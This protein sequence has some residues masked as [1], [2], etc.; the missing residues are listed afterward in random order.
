MNGRGDNQREVDAVPLQTAVLCVDCESVTD[1][2]SNQ[3]PVCGS[4][5]IFNLFKVLG[6]T[7]LKR[8]TKD[9]SGVERFVQ[10]DLKMTIS[11]QQMRAHDLNEIVE[12]IALLI[13]P[14]LARGQASFHINVKPVADKLGKR[15][16]KVA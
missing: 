11:L 8:K 7:L 3:C 2:R 5:S 14:K 15:G 4:R 6:G 13:T 16:E 9:S 12:T 10:F 1:S